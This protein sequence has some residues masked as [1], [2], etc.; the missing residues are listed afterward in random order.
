MYV[1]YDVDA[2]SYDDILNIFAKGVEDNVYI[3][4]YN[5]HT[6]III[7]PEEVFK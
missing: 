4:T 2:Y 6:R 5:S 3:G 1:V 7:T